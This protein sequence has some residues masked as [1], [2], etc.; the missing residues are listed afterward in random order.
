[1][2]ITQANDMGKEKE[3]ACARCDS[4]IFLHALKM[5]GVAPCGHLYH[6]EC[7]SLAPLQGGAGIAQTGVCPTCQRD[8]PVDGLVVVHL[9]CTKLPPVKI[10]GLTREFLLSCGG[11][12]SKCPH[13]NPGSRGAIKIWHC[14]KPFKLFT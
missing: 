8:L 4:G 12:V 11:N 10:I 1:M 13:I 2:A 7:Y 6:E 5:E 9:P 14:T 3:M